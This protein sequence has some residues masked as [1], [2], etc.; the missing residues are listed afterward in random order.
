MF[1]YI[2][3]HFRFCADWQKLANQHKTLNEFQR[4][5]CASKDGNAR[6]AEKNSTLSDQVT[7][8]HKKLKKS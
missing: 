1:V 3:T 4:N 7:M 2:E 5:N 8:C 6:V